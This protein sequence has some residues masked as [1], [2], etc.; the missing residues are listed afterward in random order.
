MS[1]ETP[2]HIRVLEFALA[3]A[4]GRV[5]TAAGDLVGF[6]TEHVEMLDRRKRLAENLRQAESDRMYAEEA[7]RDLGYEVPPR[8][9]DKHV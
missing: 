1:D 6:D 8:E 9:E 7:I 2:F 3:E 4:R 5:D